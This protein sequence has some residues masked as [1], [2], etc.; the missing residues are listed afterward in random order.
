MSDEIPRRN[1]GRTGV[2]VSALGVGG[3]HLG[4]AKTVDEAGRRKG[5]IALLSWCWR[6]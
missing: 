2:Q 3:H 6:R 4:D 5:C 1:L